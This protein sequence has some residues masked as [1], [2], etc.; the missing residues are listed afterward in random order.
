MVGTGGKVLSQTQADMDM[1]GV[2]KVTGD[3]RDRG[4][5]ML[6]GEK[7]T[8][9]KGFYKSI[10][11]GRAGVTEYYMYDATNFRLRELALG[12]ILPEMF[13][14][15]APTSS[16]LPVPSCQQRR[17]RRCPHSPTLADSRS[18]LLRLLRRPSARY[19]HEKNKCRLR[20]RLFFFRAGYIIPQVAINF[21]KTPCTI[22]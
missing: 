20:R 21:N 19:P 13:A 18:A 3:A 10:V 11:G 9:V 1:Y 15:T 12:G 4:Y 8:N 7:I 14:K 17:R 5:V 2:T 22:P 16:L 6:E